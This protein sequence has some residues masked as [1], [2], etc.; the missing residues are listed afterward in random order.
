MGNAA[1]TGSA[2]QHRPGV[3]GAGQLSRALKANGLL[4]CPLSRGLCQGSPLA[5]PLFSFLTTVRMAFIGWKGRWKKRGS[6][7]W[8][9]GSFTGLAALQLARPFLLV[10]LSVPIGD[11][12][13]QAPL[14]PTWEIK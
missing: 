5:R 4:Q 8:L 13:F 12:R 6:E 7:L 3:E 9:L 1:L 11:S 10:G 2:P 14:L